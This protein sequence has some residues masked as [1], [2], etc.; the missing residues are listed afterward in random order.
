M[1]KYGCVELKPLQSKAQ[2]VDKGTPSIRELPKNRSWIAQHAKE[3][4]SSET[5]LHIYRSTWRHIPEVTILSSLVV[6]FYFLITSLTLTL[7]TW[8]IW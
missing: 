5:V 1:T 3:V 4:R 6:I 7:L 2:K 8:R